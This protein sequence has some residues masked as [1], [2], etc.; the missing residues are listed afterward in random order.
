MTRTSDQ[1][2]TEWLVLQVQSG[3]RKARDALAAQWY[4]LLQRYAHALLRNRE[5]AGD[6]VQDTFIT[7]ERGIHLLRD[8]A[9]YPSWVYRILHRRCTDLIRKRRR[10]G[11]QIELPDTPDWETDAGLSQDA[12]TFL[13]GDM[14]T[15]M[16]KAMQK[17]KPASYLVIH[18]YYLHDLDVAEIAGI[19]GTPTGTVKSRLSTARNALKQ[20]LGGYDEQTGR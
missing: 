6:A 13:A 8:P 17:L 9:A 1:I 15:D 16:H 14:H 3:N 7:V 5:D 20:Y 12:E 19:T 11:I 2:L 18:L 4:P 10:Q